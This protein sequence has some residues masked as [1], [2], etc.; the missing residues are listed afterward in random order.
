METGDEIVDIPVMDWNHEHGDNEATFQATFDIDLDNVEWELESPEYTIPA[1]SVI[2]SANPP[3]QVQTYLPCTNCGKVVNR[4]SM[5]SHVRAI[6]CTTK[7][8]KAPTI[9][10]QLSL[11]KK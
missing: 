10:R 4:K 7:R 3:K 2:E 11:T 6:T 9:V 1:I 8:T 5:K